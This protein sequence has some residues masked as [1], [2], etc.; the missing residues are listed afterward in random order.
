MTKK[1]FNPKRFRLIIDAFDCHI[2]LLSNKN[3]L[4]ELVKKIAKMIDMKIIKGPEF[5]EGIPENPGLS[6]FAIID[7]SHISIHTFTNSKEFSLDIFS[8][9]PFDYEKVEN[10]IKKAFKIKGKQISKSIVNNNFKSNSASDIEIIEH[11]DHKFMFINKYLWMW[12]TPQ[13]RDLQ[14]D[15]ADQAFGNVLVVGY[16]LGL[17]PEYLLKNPK[18]KSVTTVEKY[19]AVMEKMKSIGPIYGKIIVSDF[20]RLPENKKYDCVIGDIW[21]EIDTKFLKDYIK[22]KKK[23]EKLLEKSGIVL[24]W[25]KDF[26]EFLIE[27]KNLPP[28]K[29]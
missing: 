14:K 27:K 3:F 26:F 20:Y 22:F 11:K 21:P 25:G 19:N 5:A 12:D 16:G 2:S 7:F 23:A 1:K 4:I 6:V 17:L 15:L 28:N 13:E 8:C 10:C 29:T 24:A 18:V 9:K